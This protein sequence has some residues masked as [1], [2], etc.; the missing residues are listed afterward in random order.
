MCCILTKYAVVDPMLKFGVGHI[1]FSADLQR[2]QKKLA[3]PDIRRRL[4]RLN[5]ARSAETNK[6]HVRTDREKGL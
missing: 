4:G 2:R 5:A 6:E 3:T 1:Y